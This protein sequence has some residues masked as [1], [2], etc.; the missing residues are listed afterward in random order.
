MDVRPHPGT[1][2]RLVTREILLD[3]LELAA[4]LGGESLQVVMWEVDAG[5]AQVWY[6]ENSVIV[7]QVND[8]GAGKVLHFWLAAGSLREVIDLSH[9]VLEWGRGVGCV[10]ATLVGRR[11]WR[12]VLPREGWRSLS[13]ER[14][15][16]EIP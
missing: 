4:R 10:R 14:M 8:K 7:T 13:A 6:D 9:R 15:E 2:V 3:R 12:R 5:M 1:G 11:G 16:R